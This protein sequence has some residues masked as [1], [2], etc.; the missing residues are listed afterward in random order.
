MSAL[1]W[2]IFFQP[3]SIMG[4]QGDSQTQTFGIVCLKLNPTLIREMWLAT[5]ASTW[6]TRYS[7]KGLSH[8]TSFS[9]NPLRKQNEPDIRQRFAGTLVSIILPCL[10]PTQSRM[11]LKKE[12][13]WGRT[14]A[15]APEHTKTSHEWNK[16]HA[17]EDTTYPPWAEPQGCIEEGQKASLQWS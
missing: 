17:W 15:V 10:L 9:K 12:K 11:T 3:T 5:R 14:A 6:D 8:G 16:S 1:L 13:G 4:A 7:L 2:A